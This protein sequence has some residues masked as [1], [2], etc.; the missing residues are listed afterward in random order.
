[1]RTGVSGKRC[2]PPESCSA[3]VPKRTSGPFG[4]A[5]QPLRRPYFERIISWDSQD[6]LT[7]QEA[8]AQHPSVFLLR[9]L[10]TVL[11]AFS[12]SP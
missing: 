8:W 12:R 10:I 4:N 6:T 2:G 11:H 1:M 3:S 5:S 7:G 9:L